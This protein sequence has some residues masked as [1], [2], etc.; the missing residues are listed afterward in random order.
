MAVGHDKFYVFLCSEDSKDIYPQNTA[1]DF[2][3]QLPERVQLSG[4]W[5]VAVAEVE[6][7]SI[8]NG[9]APAYLWMEIDLCDTSIVGNKK[10]PV[11]RQL[12]VNSDSP[13]DTKKRLSF[14]H[15]F[16]LPIRHYDFDR[17]HIH[18]R[19][20]AGHTASFA[21]GILYC[22]LQISRLL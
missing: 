1:Q 4:T 3:V 10:L 17:I 6:Y 19:E 12:P 9:V 15:L 8:F 16:H 2:I 5:S 21:G 18:I 14:D 22:A 11:L 20:P 13:K 7:P